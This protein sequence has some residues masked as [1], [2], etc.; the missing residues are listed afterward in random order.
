MY[1]TDSDSQS[2]SPKKGYLFRV[3][4]KKTDKH[5]DFEG[6]IPIEGRTY[7]LA[8]WVRVSKVGNKYL[9]LSA[10][11]DTGQGRDGNQAPALPLQKAQKPK[12]SN[13]ENLSIPF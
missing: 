2:P 13:P 9:S 6:S 1:N 10:R 7:K 8:G 4:D 5:P 12:E 11:L 3:K